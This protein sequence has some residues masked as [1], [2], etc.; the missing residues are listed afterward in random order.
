MAK[1]RMFTVNAEHH[2]RA[3][4]PHVWEAIDDFGA[5]HRF[6]P[7]IERSRITNG[8]VSGEGSEREISLYDGSIIRQRIVDYQPGRSMAIE[9]I[10][11]THLIRHHLVEIVVLPVSEQ[12]CRLSYRASFRAPF[13]AL[14]MPIGLLYKPVLLSRYG[15][16]LRGLERYV[17]SRAAAPAPEF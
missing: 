4:A 14:G 3:P 6:N 10:E 9:V 12:A 2:V 5:H 16:V 17:R 15:H 11:S 7:F 8:I 13:G 1:A